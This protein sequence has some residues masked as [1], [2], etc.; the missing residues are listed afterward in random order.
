MTESDVAARVAAL[1]RE[2]QEL[3][4][5]QELLLRLLSTTR[6]LSSMLEY[7]GAPHSFHVFLRYRPA[8]RTSISHIH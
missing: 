7:Y 2:I 4:A 6:P 3:K 5:V 1:E 8:T